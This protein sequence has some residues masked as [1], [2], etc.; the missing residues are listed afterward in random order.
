MRH[1][2]S[3]DGTENGI[4]V[5]IAESFADVLKSKEDEQELTELLLRLHGG[6]A[7]LV[8]LN[9]DRAAVIKFF[10]D[11]YLNRKF[12]QIAS[13]SATDIHAH[14]GDDKP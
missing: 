6:P 2:G 3:W 4:G 13:R 5:A 11:V 12:Y 9:L 7:N 10:C 8:G 14:N 1:F